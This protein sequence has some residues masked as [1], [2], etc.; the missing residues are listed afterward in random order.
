[1]QG[2]GCGVRCA[3]KGNYRIVDRGLVAFGDKLMGTYS[4]MPDI[5][6]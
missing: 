4:L 1:M 3:V 2:A 5:N 6:S